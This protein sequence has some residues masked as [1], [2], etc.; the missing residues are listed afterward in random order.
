[1]ADKLA[2]YRSK[3]N[4]EHSSDN[5]D[6]K[7]CDP[8]STSVQ[9]AARHNSRQR[10]L[11]SYGTDSASISPAA[12]GTVQQSPSDT[13]LVESSGLDD[14]WPLDSTLPFDVLDYTQLSRISELIYGHP[15]FQTVDNAQLQPY[16]SGFP[17]RV[18]S[19]TS[20]AVDASSQDFGSQN[21]QLV[22]QD[23]QWFNLNF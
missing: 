17:E 6:S 5:E 16:S 22:P 9:S 8:L 1:M 18:L 3:D 2:L 7:L 20:Y 12:N 15:T 14:S 19:Q 4:V 21:I 11:D 13:A 10:S 23:L